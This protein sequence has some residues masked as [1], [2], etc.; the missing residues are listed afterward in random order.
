LSYLQVSG[1]TVAAPWYTSNTALTGSI[2][3]IGAAG[4]TA[5]AL[6][7]DDDEQPQSISP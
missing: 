3:F 6:D 1:P 2:A 7:D 5:L 4:A